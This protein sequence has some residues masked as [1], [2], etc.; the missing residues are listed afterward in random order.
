MAA[1]FPGCAVCNR[2]NEHRLIV[3]ICCLGEADKVSS[4]SASVVGNRQLAGIGKVPVLVGGAVGGFNEC[5]IG[6]YGGLRR[7]IRY[8]CRLGAEHRGQVG[9]LDRQ[10]PAGLAVLNLGLRRGRLS[11]NRA[12]LADVDQYGILAAG[13]RH[14]HG[15]LAVASRGELLSTILHHGNGHDVILI[16]GVCNLSGQSL[17][18]LGHNGF[19]GFI[20]YLISGF[21]GLCCCILS[22]DSRN[23]I[24]CS[25]KLL[26]RGRGNRGL[27]AALADDLQVD[28][29]FITVV[30]CLLKR[31][32]DCLVDSNGA[33]G[34]G[35][36]ADGGNVFTCFAGVLVVRAAAGSRGVDSGDELLCGLLAQC[37]IFFGLLRGHH[38]LHAGQVNIELDIY[39]LFTLLIG[40]PNRTHTRVCHLLAGIAHIVVAVKSSHIALGRK[41]RGVNT[42]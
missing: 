12:V 40:H 33:I 23:Q 26:C 30:S 1:D 37:A 36:D 11:S 8:V 2:L 17:K 14:L 32:N 28:I 13:D 42:R 19:L 16:L 18:S 3:A 41:V 24:I 7:D 22:L 38:D 39:S 34:D 27:R 10:I 31:P 9:K 29:V 35:P 20:C 6:S 4:L 15:D 5:D 21:L 25:I